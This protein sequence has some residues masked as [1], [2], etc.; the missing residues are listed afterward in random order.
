MTTCGYRV[1]RVTPGVVRSL[2]D[3]ELF[4]RQL[5]RLLDVEL[6]APSEVQALRRRRLFA[7][8]MPQKRD[9]A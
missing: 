8:L 3:A 4:A 7:L 9:F 5:A 1:L 6:E 2:Y